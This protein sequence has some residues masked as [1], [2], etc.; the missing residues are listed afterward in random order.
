MGFADR[1]RYALINYN[2]I[3]ATLK[4]TNSQETR[5]WLGSTLDIRDSL[6]EIGAI[7]QIDSEG[8][9]NGKVA[10]K[11]YQEFRVPLDEQPRLKEAYLAIAHLYSY[12]YDGLRWNCQE[13]VRLVWQSLFNRELAE[14]KDFWQ[15][16]PLRQL[17]RGGFVSS[18]Q[19]RRT[20]P[21]I[22]HLLLK[23]DLLKDILKFLKL[24]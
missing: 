17:A 13:L 9:G 24:D 18:M 14:I 15:A 4:P 3:L 12:P 5:H 16:K 1:N 2:S 20:Y 22:I 11:L 19:L 7:I 23:L 8:Q 10:D 6:A 21:T